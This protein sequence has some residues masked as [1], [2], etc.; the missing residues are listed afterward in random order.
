[1]PAQF[2]RLVNHDVTPDRRDTKRSLHHHSRENRAETL[3]GIRLPVHAAAWELPLPSPRWLNVYLRRE[4]FI[5]T[6]YFRQLRV[7]LSH[8]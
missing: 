1:M 2:T 7:V 5:I 4:V 3:P 8:F 6:V